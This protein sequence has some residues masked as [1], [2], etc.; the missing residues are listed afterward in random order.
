MLNLDSLNPPQREAV[1]ATEGALLV[2]AGA[3]SGKTRVIAHRVAHLL[4]KGVSARHVLAVTFTNKAAAE[5]KERIKALAAK[6]Q[7]R[8]LTVSTFHA[9][10]ASVLR[11]HAPLVSLPKKFAILDAG[12]QVALVRRAMR[13]VKIDDRK[14]DPRRVLSIVSRARTSGKPPAP[15]P[16]RDSD[17]ELIAAE[18]LPRYE[19]ALRAMSA[20]DFDDLLG[21]PLRL[22]KD[23]KDVLL[24]W[25]EKLRYL[26]VDEY[27]DTNKQQFELLK[28]LAGPRQNICA[29]GDDDQSIYGWRGAEISNIL[30]FEKTFHGAKLVKLTQNYRSTASI[31]DAANAVIAKNPK[32]MGKNLWTE[33]GRGHNLVHAVAAGEDEE[34]R[35]IGDEIVRL[36][37]EEQ[38]P[39]A[40]FA[41]LY[42]T[43]AQ[44]RPVEETLRSLN[45]KYRVVGG[46]KFFDRK[47]VKD[48]LAYLKACVHPDDDVSIARI[49]NVPA[50][51]LGDS[52]VEKVHRRSLAEGTSLFA[53]LKKAD[54]FE[55]LKAARPKLVAFAELLERFGE[56]LAQP[57]WSAA[58]R[59]LSEE[60][61]LYEEIRRTAESPMI[62]G[63]KIENVESLLRSIA[64]SEERENKR[65]ADEALEDALEAAAKAAL[66]HAPANAP[67]A[68]TAEVAVPLKQPAPS[69]N[70]GLRGYLQRLALDSR[71]DDGE[72]GD[73]ITLMTLH[74]AKGLEFPVVFLC[75]MEEGLLPHSG[76]GF[77]DSS[78]PPASMLPDN[79]SD[80]R[81]E[82]GGRS[83][84]ASLAG[85]GGEVPPSIEEERRLAY[86]GITRARERLYLTRAAERVKRGKATPRT[87]SRFVA[88][89]PEALVDVLDLS[90]PAEVRHAA[91][92]EKAGAFFKSLKNIFGD[93]EPAA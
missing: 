92:A 88:D 42:R 68:P 52:T 56:R 30:K 25:R 50:R 84:T 14:F 18:V 4:E 35:Y 48:L 27:Q 77:E 91:S 11:E 15:K 22:L 9:F 33:Q 29:V 12:D 62:A 54:A 26:L 1:L 85:G 73:E 34:A 24:R 51:G 38:R 86:V 89:I 37:Y 6:G 28:L 16:G 65:L 64:S 32:R 23:D 90:V 71:D 44:S 36:M 61:G 78:E 31:L 69:L 87:P 70:T 7:A 21:L 83:P 8:G 43:N 82:P 20:V 47:E 41:V 60:I 13:D 80:G 79:V 3:G 2:L 46:P 57:G 19:Q 63:R 45:L 93:D 10:G 74:S 66:A 58:A 39:A 75:G 49:V 72:L 67:D 59:A 81:K 55:E 76:R 53:A 5:M 17:Y 40:H